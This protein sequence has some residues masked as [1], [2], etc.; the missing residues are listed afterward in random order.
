MSTVIVVIPAYQPDQRLVDLVRTLHRTSPSTEVLVV[1]DGSG[2]AYRRVFDGVRETGATVLTH[3]VNRGKGRAL[4]TAFGYVA[5]RHPGHDVVCADSDG[6]HSAVDV[7]RVAAAVGRDR[8]MVLGARRFS[9]DVPLRSRVGNT[10]VRA[11]VRL[12]TGLDLH[13]TQTGLRGYPADLLEW[14]GTVPGERFEYEMRVL[15]EAGPAGYDVHEI[16]IATIYLDH[17]ASSHFRPVV[18]SVRVLVPV[19]WFAM[20]SLVGFVIDTAVLL[21][22]VPLSGSLAVGVVGARLL[23]GTANLMLNR[24]VT[25]RSGRHAPLRGVVRRYVTL[26]VLLL[27]GSYLGL[28]ALTALGLPLLAAKVITDLSLLTVSYQVQRAL[29]FRHRHAAEVAASAVEVNG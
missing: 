5:R 11:L 13:D 9:G 7:L 20:A 26:A 16:E 1:D 6:Q 27:A 21:V 22:L 10:G 18:D 24:H 25:F 8:T 23:S 15:L 12:V 2:P 19:L 3:D 17:N 14:L 4:K 28:A 29:V